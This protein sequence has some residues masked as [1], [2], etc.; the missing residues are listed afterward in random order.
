MPATR[1]VMDRDVVIGG[2]SLANAVIMYGLNFIGEPS[3]AMFRRRDLDRKSAQ[4][5]ARPFQFNGEEVRGA[6]DLAIWSRLLIQGNAAFFRARL[7]RF[8]THDEQGQAQPDVVAL[9]IVGIRG[10]Q[11]QWIELG[12]FRRFPPHLFLCQ[13]LPRD[14]ADANKWWL[15]P[16]L[17]LTPSPLSPPDALRAWRAT[18]LHT[19]DHP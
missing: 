4:D 8:R 17:S 19:F 5:D 13:P 1:P 7:S 15:A 9:S 18:K 6:F 12:L 3:T 10:L 2:L 11:R 14:E 16:R